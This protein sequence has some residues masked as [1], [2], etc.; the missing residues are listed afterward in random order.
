MLILLIH[1]N[2]GFSQI[3]PSSYENIDY[4]MTFGKDADKKWGDDDN[5]QV[6]FFV[7]PKSVNTP[8]YIRVFDPQ[9]GG[10]YDT[11]NGSFDTKTSFALY[12][13][14][15]C[16]SK[17]EAQQTNPVP[18]YDKG[19]LI[20]KKVFGNE[21]TYD[22]KWYTF[23]PINPSEGEYSEEFQ[24]Y[25]F[26]MICKGIEG[27]DGNAYKYSLSKEKD[28][29]V[30]IENGNI[31]TYEMTFK[32][33][34]NNYKTAHVYPFITKNIE[35]LVIKNFDA[36]DDIN[37]R[38]TSIARK[39][40]KGNVSLDG[41]WS[42]TVIDILTKE[43]NT[44]IDIQ[45]IKKNHTNNDMS[46]FILNQYKNAVPLFSVPIGGKPS[47]LYKVNVKYSFK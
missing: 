43:Y 3:A 38:I 44:S 13:G 19:R 21:T 14:K 15:Y 7:V 33:A 39:L 41:R 12:G 2:Y 29:N 17:K 6:H 36:D 42:S 27:N 22:N 28:A 11:K 1:S 35:S 46:F 4:L 9:I 23:G 8:V 18:G 45:L 37:I 26:K 40:V 32:L 24:G 31:F 20:K 25:I 34:K 10:K 5:V 47:Y 16:F 30:R